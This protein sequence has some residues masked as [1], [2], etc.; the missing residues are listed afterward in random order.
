MDDDIDSV[1]VSYTLKMGSKR[2]KLRRQQLT[3][4]VIARLFGLSAEAIFLTS[5]DG[6]METPSSDGDFFHIDDLLAWTVNQTPGEGSR[7][8]LQSSTQRSLLGVTSFYQPSSLSQG[9]SFANKWQPKAVAGA[10]S[11]RGSSS[12]QRNIEIYT[13]HDGKPKHV[14]THPIT[15]DENTANVSSVRATISNEA[16]QEQPVTLLDVKNK[17]VPDVNGTKGC[18]YANKLQFMS[19]TSVCL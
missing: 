12:W 7:K 3:T 1:A 5:D 14:Y 2:Y 16:F 6:D 19:R 9:G 8:Q 4:A 15:Q 18:T 17:V 10:K 11:S 13:L